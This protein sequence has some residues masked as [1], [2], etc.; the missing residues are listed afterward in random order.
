MRTLL[1]LLLHSFYRSCGADTDIPD[2]EQDAAFSPP[3]YAAPGVS[4]EEMIFHPFIQQQVGSKC[5]KQTSAC[6]CHIFLVSCGLSRHISPIIF[7][8]SGFG[9]PGCW[10]TT[11]A[12]LCWRKRMKAARDVVSTVV[13]NLNRTL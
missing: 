3:I 13:Y 4:T 8:I 7:E 5:V 10:A 11:A 9:F 12:W 1:L 2:T 6:F